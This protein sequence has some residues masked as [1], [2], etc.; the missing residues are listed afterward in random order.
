VLMDADNFYKVIPTSKSS[1]LLKKVNDSERIYYVNTKAPWPVT[2]RDGVYSMNFSQ[3]PKTKVVTVIVENLAD[4]Y[5][6]QEGHIR[7]PASEGLWIFKPLP[8]GKVEITYEYVA[9]PGGS[10]PTWL[11]N[12]SAV[13]IP[14]ET[15]INLKKRVALEQ[16][17]GQSFTFLD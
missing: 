2:D 13:N 7:V 5:P 10:I 1:K 6:E 16:Y 8:N 15:I 14:F 3:D 4:Y 12:S 17:E 11:A 9:D